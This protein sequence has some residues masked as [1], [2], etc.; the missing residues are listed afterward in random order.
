MKKLILGMAAVIALSACN[1]QGAN[2]VG[3]PSTPSTAS[4]EG[5]IS[6]GGGGTL[7]ADPASTWQIEEIVKSAKR[8]LRLYFIGEM[9]SF[10]KYDSSSPLDKK[11]YFGKYT[12]LE[13]LNKTDLEILEDKPCYDGTHKE[14]DG[15][16][17]GSRPNTI[18]ISA[19]RI[20][21][22]VAKQLARN[23]V[24]AL[25]AHELSHLVGATEAEA[26]ELQRSLIITFDSAKIEENTTDD[27]VRDMHSTDSRIAYAIEEVVTTFDS[28]SDKELL[29]KMQAIL[30][31]V[32]EFSMK[33]NGYPF[34]FYQMPQLD[35]LKIQTKRLMIAL[36]YVNGLAPNQEGQYWKLEL[37]QTFGKDL[38]LTP[39]EFELRRYPDIVPDKNT[40][41]NELIKKIQSRDDVLV[42][43]TDLNAY[44]RDQMNYLWAFNIGSPLPKL[45]VGPWF[46]ATENPWI[47]F[48]GQYEVMDRNCQNDGYQDSPSASVKSIEIYVSNPG[49][50]VHFRTLFANGSS[51]MVLEDNGSAFVAGSTVTLDGNATSASL[52][53]EL[54]YSWGDFW[55]KRY[56]TFENTLDGVVWKIE[57]GS[58]SNVSGIRASAS[59][60]IKMKLN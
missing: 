19:F 56:D 60:T 1:E 32:S 12:I 27:L 24:I 29:V 46:Q 38:A 31:N 59:C 58:K 41:P 54:G 52:Y 5:G 40:W 48:V 35:Y 42:L 8:D 2:P 23:E 16:I 13:A 7:P 39:H 30:N 37:E 9:R 15:S 25:I 10:I 43:L 44:F 20:A 55:N 14:V 50:E 4:E 18:C 45:L 6:S 47:K 11:L 17:Y 51:D 21:P 26:V 34:S 22:K 57:Q 28:L 3:G 53:S 36:W 49:N 33:A